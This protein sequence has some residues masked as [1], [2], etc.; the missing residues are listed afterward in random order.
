M[1]RMLGFMIGVT[2]GALVG[3]TVA[4]LL[5]PEPGESLRGKIRARGANLVGEVRQAG[6]ARRAELTDR[7]ESLRAPRSPASEA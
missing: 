5:A 1:R 7:L 2:I 6:D 3:S 4:L